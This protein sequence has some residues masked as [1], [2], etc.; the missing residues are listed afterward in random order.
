MDFHMKTT[1]IIPDDLFRELKR[2]AVEAGTTLSRVVEDS[3][4]RGLMAR[5]EKQPT[6]E[7][8]PSFHMGRPSADVSDRKALY[9]ILE[10]D[11][12]LR[13]RHRLTRL[14]RKP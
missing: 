8:L 5:R 3:V 2:A 12:H 11:D 1:V 6:I 10:G 4:R 13:R 9:E 7:P 14:R